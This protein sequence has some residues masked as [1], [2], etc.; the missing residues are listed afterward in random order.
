MTPADLR[1]WL[2]TRDISLYEAARQL[3]CSRESLRQWLNGNRRIPRYIALACAALA[4]GLPA[5]GGNTKENEG[6]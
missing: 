2:D 4:F 3:G 5:W 1:H 6:E